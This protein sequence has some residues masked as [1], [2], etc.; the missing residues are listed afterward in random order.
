MVSTTDFGS[1][2]FSSSLDSPTLHKSEKFEVK[3]YR[4]EM[5]CWNVVKHSNIFRQK[6]CS[7]LQ[8]RTAFWYNYF[9]LQNKRYNISGG[10][11]ELVYRTCL[12]NKRALT[13][14][15]GSNPSPSALGN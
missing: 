2:S 12:E 11:A 7:K 6:S 14:P 8:K 5:R 13:G 3:Q 1:V 9:E 4:K 10:M 15:G